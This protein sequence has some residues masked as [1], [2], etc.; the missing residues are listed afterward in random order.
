MENKNFLFYS[1]WGEILDIAFTIKKEGHNVKMFIESEYFQEVGDGFIDKVLNFD[2]NID[3]ADII[4]F[5]YSGYGQKV[6]ELKAKGKHV[7]GGSEYMDKLEFD[8]SFG[9]DELKKH[10]IKILPYKEF[11]S[12]DKAIEYVEE[13]P[14][15]Y[16]IKPCGEIQN[17]KQFLFVGKDEDGEDIK[18]MLKAYKKTWGNDF[19]T[20]QLQ[21]KV[22][23]VEIGVSA[24]FNGNEFIT[25]ININF[26]HKKLFPKEIGISTG[27]MGTSMF[28]ADKN[29]IFEETL[30]KMEPIFKKENYIGSIDLN[31]IVNGNGIYPLEFTPRFGFPQIFIQRYGILDDIG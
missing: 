24:F 5:D 20:I 16:V 23:G 8:R 28:W 15:S 22:T 17:F 11:N 25:P 10:K 4:I 29:P 21:K 26:E 19:G 27:E 6:S 30:K 3:W 18:R 14:N 13:N 9:Q 31:C 12:L 1:K 7:I 2:E